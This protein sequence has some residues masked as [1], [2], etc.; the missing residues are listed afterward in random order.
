MGAADFSSLV[1]DRDALIQDFT[2]YVRLI[3][4]IEGGVDFDGDGTRDLDP[5][6]IFA[7]GHSRG[8]HE[9]IPLAAVEPRVIAVVPDAPGNDWPFDNGLPLRG[10]PSVTIDAATSALQQRDYR[11]AWARMPGGSLTL[12][13]HLRAAPLDGVPPKRVL[14]LFSRP[15]RTIPNP[16]TSGLI[17][18]GGLED[19]TLVLQ[20]QAFLADFG[21]SPTSDSH[22]WGTFW[23]NITLPLPVQNLTKATQSALAAFFLWDGT[24][25]EIPKPLGFEQYFQAPIAPLPEDLGY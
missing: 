9:D 12:T 14:L 17:R 8:G 19:R 23:N 22:S 20:T 11:H 25:S 1:A 24:G 10:Q 18:A 3:R 21:L 5:D 6:K 13:P 2:D 7:Y 15:D 16:T 4:M